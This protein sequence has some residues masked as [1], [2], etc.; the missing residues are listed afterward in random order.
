M[1]NSSLETIQGRRGVKKKTKI[2]NENENEDDDKSQCEQRREKPYIT[3]NLNESEP[4]VDHSQCLVLT[5]FILR[6]IMVT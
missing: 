1:T 6:Y 5:N 4:V 3:K 2:S